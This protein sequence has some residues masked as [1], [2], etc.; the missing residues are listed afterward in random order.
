[1][2][3]KA[4]LLPL[5]LLSPFSIAQRQGGPPQ[6]RPVVLAIDTNKDGQFSVEEIA[7]ASAGLI[8]LDANHDGQLTSLEYLPNQS[9]PNANKPDET[10][11]RLMVLDKNG[12][13]VLTK[14]EV[15]ERMQGMFDR[16]DTN[17]DGKITPDE[18]KA[19]AS[20]QRGPNGRA[21]R[22]GE[23]TRRDP[24][25]NALDTDHD[26]VISAAEIA[27]APTSLKA[28]DKD[29]D[30]VISAA[31]MRPR[32]MTPADRAKH[33]LDEWDTNKDGKITKAEAPEGMQQRFDS[34][35]SNHDGFLTED[36]LVV[37]FTNN[38]PQPRRPEGGPNA[39]EPRP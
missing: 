5:L 12:D 18:I 28:L 2:K 34:M 39:Q 24:V 1:M 22:T 3:T 11:Q 21:E 14:D 19:S 29:G 17:H 7:A 33:M 10:V 37:F 38:P 31:E 15:P 6:P 9:D 26:G 4:S 32:E 30:G 27:A 23:A 13:G 20:T 36:E 35:D 25:L 16:L 8:T